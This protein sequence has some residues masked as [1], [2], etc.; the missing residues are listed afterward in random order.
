MIQFF[1][2]IFQEGSKA[3]IFD[4]LKEVVVQNLYNTHDYNGLPLDDEDASKFISDY[5]AIRLGP[6]R[7]RMLRVK[8]SELIP[9]FCSTF[10]MFPHLAKPR[11]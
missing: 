4:W 5:Y 2:C 7:L 11:I 6:P 8:P 3:D 10:C 9:I 1:S